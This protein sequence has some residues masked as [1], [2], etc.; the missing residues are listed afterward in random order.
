MTP[1]FLL[2]GNQSETIF[3][4]YWLI[5]NG[6]IKQILRKDK[7]KG[8]RRNSRLLK[9]HLYQ[10]YFEQPSDDTKFQKNQTLE[11]LVLL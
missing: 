6:I 10:K 11:T 9:R 7:K 4:R 8:L 1:N 5:K 2:L 3:S